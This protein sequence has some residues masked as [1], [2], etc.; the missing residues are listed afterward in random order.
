MKGIVQILFITLPVLAF[1]QTPIFKAK[2]DTNKLLLGEETTVNYEII[3]PA[4]IDPQTVTFPNLS[5]SLED[6][7]ELRK[8]LPIKNNSFNDENGDLF[9]KISQE[10]II[11]NFD[12]GEFVLPPKIATIGTDS[13]FSNPLI[14]EINPVNIKND[15]EIKDIKN[16][17]KDPFTFW[18]NILLKLKAIYQWIIEHWIAL[19]CIIFLV[20]LFLNRKKIFKKENNE[21]AD[22]IPIPVQLLKKLDQI[23]EEKLWQNGKYKL[24]FSKID[25]ILWEFIEYK[26]NTPTFEKTSKEILDELKLTSILQD[27]ISL[28]EKLFN[29][30]NMVKFAKQIPNQQENEFALKFPRSFIEKELKSEIILEEYTNS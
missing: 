5:D 22:K 20:Y 29:I 27:D 16:I 15:N 18:E 1:G 17:K 12:S 8:V 11:A 21:V 10:I 14:L 25:E 30:S 23:E 13:I 28:L 2:S 7:W 19:I 4:S 9:M 26:Y 3:I 6:N 24:Y